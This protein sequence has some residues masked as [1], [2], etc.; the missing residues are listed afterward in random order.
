MDI[1]ESNSSI[2]VQAKIEYTKQ[3]INV[4][5]SHMYDGIKSIYDDSKELYKQN[6]STSLLF[7]FRTLL[8]KIP[9]WNNELIVAETD[10][11]IEISKCDWLDDL[12][13]AV[14]ISHTKILMSIS[15]N[16][17]NNKINLTVPKLINFI[18][19]CYIN[20]A[21]E[22][23]KNPLLFSEDITGYEYQKNIDTIEHIICDCI[24]NTIRIS[25]PVKEIL[26]EHLDIYDNKST[27]ENKDNSKL[28]NELKELLIKQNDNQDKE[29]EGNDSEDN[30]EEDSKE[31]LE[32]DKEIEGNDL[33]D[34]E[35]LSKELEIEDSAEVVKETNIEE[36]NAIAGHI[37]IEGNVYKNNDGYVSPDEDALSEKCENLEINDIPDIKVDENNVPEQVKEQVY[38]NADIIKNTAKEN[39]ELY[40]KLI[41]INDNNE[42]NKEEEP[43]IVSKSENKLD[44]ST[45]SDIKTPI[46]EPKKEEP[47]SFVSV[48]E[49]L[50]LEEE[51]R[52]YDNKDRI[53]DITDKENI[54][55][56][57]SSQPSQKKEEIIIEAPPNA[58]EEI[59]YDKKELSYIEDVIDS[60]NKSDKEIIT[61]D[62]KDDDKETVDFFYDDLK[63][64]S[65][66]KGLTMEP[67]DETRYTLFDDL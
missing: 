7:I 18:H 48:E 10:R 12:V 50:K 16:T 14:Y 61:V 2:Y 19:K 59:K 62:K 15:S 55:K 6:S 22:I 4:L 44:E 52:K 32:D 33:E 66:K 34:E 27:S 24:E 3:L 31:D 42:E 67:V 13:T 53:V 11:I 41:K 38:D 58:K 30:K 39:N 47:I 9:E 60:D 35:E 5:Q 8:E 26:K 21:R 1:M 64:M 45:I 65:E 43:I 63:N 25:L 28:L 40:E 29:I 46:P 51:Q 56:T 49:K 54:D 23:W 57:I 37:N 17:N 20:I 36:N